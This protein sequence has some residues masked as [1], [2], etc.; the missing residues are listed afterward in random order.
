MPAPLRWLAVAVFFGAVC[1][2]ADPP[3]CLAQAPLT[4]AALEMHVHIPMRDGAYLNATLFRPIGIAT[5]VPTV[6]M[7]TPYAGDASHPSGSYFARHGLAY[8]IVDSRGRGDSSGVFQPLVNDGDDG[9][10]VVE[11]LARQPWSDGHVGMFGG[12]YAGLN[13]WQIAALHPPHLTTIAPVASARAGVDF[14][15][16]NNIFQPYI[17]QWLTYTAGRPLYLNIFGDDQLW[18]DLNKRVYQ[19]GLPFSRLDSEAGNPSPDFQ[20]WIRH[21]DLDAYWRH[22]SPSKGEVAGVKLPML[23]ITGAH[24]DDQMGVMSYLADL[25]TTPDGALP[26]NYYL[27]IGPWDHFGTREPRLDVHGEHFGQASLVDLMRLHLEWYRYAMLGEP[28]PTFL[29]KQVAYYVSGDGAECWKYADS[30]AG[31]TRRTQTL[32]LN[33]APG[34]GSLQLAGGLQES[35]TGASGGEWISDPADLSHAEPLKALPGD[36]LHGDGLVFQSPPL[37]QQIEIDGQVRIKLSLA[38]DGPDADIGYRLYL[39]TPDG[40]AHWLTQA[41]VRARYRRSLSKPELVIPGAIE[42][43]DLTPGQWFAI[44]AP[45]GARLRLVVESINRPDAEKNWNSAKPVA[46]QTS[47]DAHRETIHLIQTADHASVITLPLGDLESE[48]VASAAG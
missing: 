40:K 29:K 8:V 32:Y 18:S 38:I 27:V 14:P 20:T 31:V 10:D 24:D 2:A 42:S 5:P 15:A 48:C 3:P 23:V 4:T 34:A 30:L 22:L 9:Y 46:E 11:W 28:R 7:I 13:Q 25:V 19:A 26:P 17:I 21:P 1:W 35:L 16:P 12:S 33:A 41:A 44:R 6:V 37:P 39:I 47:A 43:Y 45:K 36:D